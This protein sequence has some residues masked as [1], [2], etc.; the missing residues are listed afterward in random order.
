MAAV[1]AEKLA[2]Y[3]AALL[4]YENFNALHAALTTAYAK[5]EVEL[6]KETLVEA[7]ALE[8]KEA[9]DTLV[10]NLTEAQEEASEAKIAADGDLEEAENAQSGALST[11]ET[12]RDEDVVS[13]GLAIEQPLA[14]LNALRETSAELD[15]ALRIATEEY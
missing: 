6:A 13:T 11:F 10:E 4:K 1:T 9:Q 8:E 15:E 3:N 14:D 12:Y 7:I 2:L 5:Q